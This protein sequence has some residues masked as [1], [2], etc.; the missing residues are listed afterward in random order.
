MGTPAGAI[1][2]PPQQKMVELWDKHTAAEFQAHDVE[3]TLATMT[4]NPHLNNIPVMTGG[5]KT[6]WV[7]SLFE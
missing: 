1:L 7:H 4:P 5:M 3:A 2:T 6:L